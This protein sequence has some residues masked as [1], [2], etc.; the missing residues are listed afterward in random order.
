M[1]PSH[2]MSSNRKQV[3]A[4]PRSL[5]INEWPHADQKGWG[6]RAVQALVCGA[7]KSKSLRRG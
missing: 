1:S 4:R 2:S 6:R 7:G 5:P 3:R